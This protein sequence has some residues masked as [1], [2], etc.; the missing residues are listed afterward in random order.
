MLSFYE[1]QRC[2]AQGSFDQY[3]PDIIFLWDS[4]LIGR[5]PPK[6]GFLSVYRPSRVPPTLEI[7][8]GSRQLHQ[9]PAQLGSSKLVV[10][11]IPDNS[12]A[13]R[14]SKFQG[15]NRAYC[16]MIGDNSQSTW[17]DAPE[18]QKQSARKGVRRFTQQGK[19][20]VR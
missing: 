10:L 17:E 2:C 5:L 18:W 6:R 19:S 15:A 16:Q 13:E 4:N 14:G 1:Q 3:P 11:P 20:K 9:L 8:H 12:E 7:L